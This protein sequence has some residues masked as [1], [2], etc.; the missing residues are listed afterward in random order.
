[1]KIDERLCS[2][3]EHGVLALDAAAIALLFMATRHWTALVFAAFTGFWGGDHWQI[4]QEIPYEFLLVAELPALAVVLV[5]GRRVPGAPAFWRRCWALGRISLQLVFC[6]HVVV[7][8]A[9]I[10]LSGL[11]EGRE[12]VILTLMALLD[13]A[14]FLSLRSRYYRTLFSEFPSSSGGRVIERD[15]P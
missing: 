1:M 2:V 12:G 3:N 5:A 15:R 8:A 13:F 7:Y 6:L 10:S 9:R 14:C 11:P 4:Y